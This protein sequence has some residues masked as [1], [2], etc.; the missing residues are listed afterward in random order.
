MRLS[1][2][3]DGLNFKLLIARNTPVAEGI[4]DK[5]REIYGQRT[6]VLFLPESSLSGSKEDKGYG[7][8]LLEFYQ[9][10]T[11]IKDLES[12]NG[13][14]VLDLSDNDTI[15]LAEPFCPK[16]TKTLLDDLRLNQREVDEILEVEGST[17]LNQKV[18]ILLRPSKRVRLVISPAKL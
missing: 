16:D 5:I 8:C 7:H 6:I 11:V 10:K 2:N 18:G 12:T 14:G 1:V 15:T 17:T 9:D 13:T 4:V 3:K